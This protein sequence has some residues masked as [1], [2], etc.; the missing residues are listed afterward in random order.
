MVVEYT[1]SRAVL[2]PGDFDPC[3][4]ARAP[5]LKRGQ[6]RTLE[7]AKSHLTTPPPAKQKCKCSLAADVIRRR[8]PCTIGEGMLMLE[9]FHTCSISESAHHTRK[10]HWSFKCIITFGSSWET[11]LE[12]V[13]AACFWLERVLHQGLRQ[14]HVIQ[15]TI[16]CLDNNNNNNPLY[17]A[18]NTQKC[19]DIKRK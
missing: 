1:L 12:T 6:K 16:W 8:S 5:C 10:S 7:T 15:S 19:K 2:A 18:V 14:Y 9:S 3:P 4:E 11:K 13:A 17:C